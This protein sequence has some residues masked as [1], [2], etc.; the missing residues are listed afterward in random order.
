M[1]PPTAA[2][3]PSPASRWPAMAVVVLLP[4]VPVMARTRRRLAPASH[5]P[6]PPATA[7]PPA[8]SAATSGRWRL[9]PGA[10]TTTSHR[11][12]ASRPPVPVATTGRP[13]GPSPS[14]GGR[15]SAS[16]GSTPS[17]ASLRTLA[18]PSTPSPHTP[19]AWPARS[20]QE[21]GGGVGIGDEVGAGRP[22]QRIDRLRRGQ[23]IAQP[24][25]QG[26]EHR[27]VRPVGPLGGQDHGGPALVDVADALPRL[28]RPGRV[29]QRLER[30]QQAEVVERLPAG[31]HL[32]QVVGAEERAEDEVDEAALVALAA[33]V[34]EPAGGVDV[35]APIA[36]LEGAVVLGHAGE[37][38]G[39]EELGVG[40]EPG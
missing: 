20:A 15:S 36:A 34:V 11:A 3:W 28:G 35:E 33:P 6:S 23:A 4:L 29:D 7:V 8:S 17:A 2:R 19:T 14:G 9:M 24:L 30:G 27:R 12:R 1:L 31:E 40:A 5:S 10:F 26:A 13:S 37:P 39:D 16:T 22:E 18:R 21:I 32:G 38:L 25:D